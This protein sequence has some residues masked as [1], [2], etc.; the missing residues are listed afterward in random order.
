M[1]SRGPGLRDVGM[2]SREKMRNR[3]A[4]EFDLLDTSINGLEILQT[5]ENAGLFN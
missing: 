1:T 2:E 3:P 4:S 5:E